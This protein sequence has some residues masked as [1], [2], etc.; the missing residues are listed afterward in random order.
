MEIHKIYKYVRNHK[1]QL[2]FTPNTV[3]TIC[4]RN[5]AIEKH[6]GIILNR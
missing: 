2:G 6:I 5:I 3:G 4:S 1:L